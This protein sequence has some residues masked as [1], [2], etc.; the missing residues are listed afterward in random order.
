MPGVV[1]GLDFADEIDPEWMRK[2]V[3]KY[4]ESN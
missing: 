1:V 3:E 2:G 4:Q